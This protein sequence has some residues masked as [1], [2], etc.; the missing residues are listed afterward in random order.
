[1]FIFSLAQVG[2]GKRHTWVSS[3]GICDFVNRY[4]RLF[5][6]SNNVENLFIYVKI[7]INMT[8]VKCCL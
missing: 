2:K 6:G 7:T 8:L 5:A 1:M 4:L 3:R